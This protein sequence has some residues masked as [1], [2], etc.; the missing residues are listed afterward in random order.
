MNITFLTYGNF[1]F[2]QSR[3]RIQRQAVNAELFTH[4]TCYNEKTI[5]NI[6]LLKKAL[7]NPKFKK[8]YENPRGAGYWIWKPLI[9]KTTL[10][11]MEPNDILIYADAGCTISSNF[12]DLI[13]I[14]ILQ[15][16]NHQSKIL[17]YKN[18]LS[19]Y[20]WTKNE[21]FHH[22]K[23][24]DNPLITTTPQI[25]AGRI[26][27][28]KSQKSVNFIDKW[29]NTAQ[30]HPHLFTDSPSTTKNHSLFKENRHD[31]SIFSVLGKKHNILALT[32]ETPNGLRATRKRI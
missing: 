2:K 12:K 25:T 31:Q 22:F 15:V 23:C 6:K 19:E 5:Q 16:T 18:R 14:Q 21:I 30:N 9:I 26:I 32:Q 4:I 8:A 10:N 3:N 20:I 29:W 24:Q 27:I 1:N 17:A 7:K 11:K 13:S 28:Q